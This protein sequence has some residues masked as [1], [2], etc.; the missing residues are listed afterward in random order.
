MLKKVTSGV[1]DTLPSSRTVSYAPVVKQSA[2]LL[3]ELF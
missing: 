2:A 3:D 1:L